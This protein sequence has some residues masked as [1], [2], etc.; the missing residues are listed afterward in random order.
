MRR[1]LITGASSGIGI[2]IAAHKNGHNTFDK[3][4]DIALEEAVNAATVMIARSAIGAEM[5]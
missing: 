5:R 1:I 3:H 2:A 4:G